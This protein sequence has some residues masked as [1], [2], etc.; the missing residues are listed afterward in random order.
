[1]FL[2]FLLSGFERS[3]IFFA[4]LSSPH[5]ARGLGF[6]VGFLVRLFLVHHASGSGFSCSVLPS[7]VQGLWFCF[8]VQILRHCA[9]GTTPCQRLGFFTSPNQVCLFAERATSWRSA[10]LALKLVDFTK[11]PCVPKSENSVIHPHIAEN[12]PTTNTHCLCP[13]RVNCHP[14]TCHGESESGL[15]IGPCPYSRWPQNQFE[16]IAPMAVLMVL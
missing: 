6:P 14:E 7:K 13:I 16:K 9:S 3:V 15:E 12:R 2:L 10:A 4:R 11:P 8:H 5:P 1:M